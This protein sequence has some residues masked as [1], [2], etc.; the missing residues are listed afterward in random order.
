VIWKGKLILL[1]VVVVGGM[2]WFAPQ[3]GDDSRGLEAGL[4][5]RDAGLACELV[6]KEGALLLDVRTAKEFSEV[7][8]PGAKH[9]WVE[10]L[11]KRLDEV[12]RYTGG[13][14][15]KPIVVYCARGGR[16]SEAKKILLE[17]GYGR[18]TNLGGL[19]DWKD[20]E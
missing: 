19:S 15:D 2:Y 17:A 7:R 20:C 9:I 5:D 4:P 13:E 18:V 14:R 8:L 16:A 1:G 11:K 6:T 3:L 12:D 10:D